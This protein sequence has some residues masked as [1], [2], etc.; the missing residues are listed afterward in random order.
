VHKATWD[1]RD[2]S[3]RRAAAGLYFYRLNAGER[4]LTRKVTLLP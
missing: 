4:T 1:G 2:D 3:G